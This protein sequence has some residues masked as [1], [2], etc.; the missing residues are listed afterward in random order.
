VVL[1]QSFAKGSES[2]RLLTAVRWASI[3]QQL[4]FVAARLSEVSTRRTGKVTLRMSATQQL[5]VYVEPAPTTRYGTATC[6]FPGASHIATKEQVA[7]RVPDS[8]GQDF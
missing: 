8:A 4:S 1:L 2:R 7:R 5:S 6:V 3:A